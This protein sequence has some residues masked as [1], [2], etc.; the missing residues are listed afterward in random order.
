MSLSPS[1]HDPLSSMNMVIVMMYGMNHCFIALVSIKYGDSDGTWIPD[2]YRYHIN[3]N[4]ILDWYSYCQ[5]YGIDWSYPS[6]VTQLG[7]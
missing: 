1:P 3:E 2:E 5:A 6:I 4:G 7:H